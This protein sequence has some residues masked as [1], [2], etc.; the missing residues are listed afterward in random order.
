M[1]LCLRYGWLPSRTPTNCECG[2]TFSVEHALSCPKGGFPS[3]RHN[4]IRDITANLLSEVCNNVCIEPHLQPISGEHLPGTTANITEGARLDIAAN[5]V[6]GG[7]FERTCF[8]V[9]VH[10]ASN[11]QTNPSLCYR[12]HE[13]VKKRAYESRIQE[14]EHSSFTPLVMSSTGGLGPAST[15]TYKRLATLLAT[16]WD[17]P[18]TSTMNWLRCRLSFSLLR[19][20]IQAIRG[21]RS[22]AGKASKATPLPIDLVISESL[23][24]GH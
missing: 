18:Y 9:R 11:R 5:G 17:Q 21:A 14:I 13:N 12:K 3:L 10:A 4:E 16:K 8:D 23:I 7:R 24:T 22:T 15:S 2:K 6:L 19:S 1:T 20:S